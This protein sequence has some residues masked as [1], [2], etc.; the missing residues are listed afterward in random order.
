MAS[1]EQ[2]FEI[3]KPV[4]KNKIIN[5]FNGID[6][7]NIISWGNIEEDIKHIYDITFKRYLLKYTTTDTERVLHHYSQNLCFAMLSYNGK[8]KQAL[9][10]FIKIFIIRQFD[11]FN[12]NN[13]FLE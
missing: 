11:S 6:Y 10:T 8:D 1:L 2:I 9:Q 13:L 7:F 3:L 4:I 12:I 5:H